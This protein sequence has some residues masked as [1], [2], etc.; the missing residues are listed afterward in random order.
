MALTA[1]VEIAEL[2]PK[3]ALV[4]PRLDTNHLPKGR[5][6]KPNEWT[7]KMLNYKS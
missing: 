7:K 1:E 2:N 4:L 5:D 3:N 6:I